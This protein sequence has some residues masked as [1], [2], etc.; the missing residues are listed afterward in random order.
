MTALPTEPQPL[1]NLLFISTTSTLVAVMRSLKRSGPP[2]LSQSEVSVIQ[3]F[4]YKTR[5]LREGKYH[6]TASSLDS[7]P[8]LH[9]HKQQIY[10]FGCNQS[11]QTGLSHFKYLREYSLLRGL[12]NTIALHLCSCPSSIRKKTFLLFFLGN[13]DFLPKMLITLMSRYLLLYLFR[14]P[15]L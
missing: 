12:S 7:V 1:P 10:L 4:N 8:L 2:P 13:R 3:S 5:L 14:G 15:I 11:G 9:K 6:C